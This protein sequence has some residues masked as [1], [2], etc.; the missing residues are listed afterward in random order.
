MFKNL[1]EK[2]IYQLQLQSEKWAHRRW[3]IMCRDNFTCQKCGAHLP[4][5]LFLQVHHKGYVSRTFPWDYPD[6]V[7]ET[8]CINCHQRVHQETS[9]LTFPSSYAITYY[10]NAFQHRDDKSEKEMQSRWQVYKQKWEEYLAQDHSTKQYPHCPSMAGIYL[11]TDEYRYYKNHQYP[12][13]EIKAYTWS[14]I[15]AYNCMK[16]WRLKESCESDMDNPD[17]WESRPKRSDKS[18]NYYYPGFYKIIY[19]YED[20]VRA[21]YSALDTND[22][23]EEEICIPLHSLI[24][25]STEWW[26]I[27]IGNTILIKRCTLEGLNQYYKKPHYDVTWQTWTKADRIAKLQKLEQEWEEYRRRYESAI[28]ANHTWHLEYLSGVNRELDELPYPQGALDFL[29]EEMNDVQ[30][31]IDYY[32]KLLC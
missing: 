13:K 2:N 17:V 18:Y 23:L 32:R 15:N 30:K 14:G 6:D 12:L 28:D 3:E 29:I 7:L 9:I 5:N 8:L 31:K 27:G 26:R 20:E 24:N 22:F 16:G 1:L 19:I 25:S 10:L 11:P 4:N 21:F